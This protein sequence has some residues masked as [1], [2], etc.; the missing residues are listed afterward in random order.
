MK[1]FLV[2]LPAFDLLSINILLKEKK[3]EFIAMYMKTYRFH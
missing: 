1:N 2:K 3:N